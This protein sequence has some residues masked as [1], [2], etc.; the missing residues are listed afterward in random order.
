MVEDG[1]SRLRAALVAWLH[2]HP[3]GALAVA[4]SGG[5]DS[6]ALLA[7]LASL[8]SARQRGL[9]ALHVDHGLVAESRD[10]AAHAEAVARRL[11]VELRILRAEV[12]AGER[13]IEAAAREARYRLFREVLAPGEWLLLAHHAEDQAE[14][15]L[16]R[17][18]RG[19]SPRLLAGM[20]AAR[21][22]GRGYLARPLLDLSRSLL[23]EAVACSGLPW[24]EDP[25]NRD[26]RFD[27]AYL[28]QNVLPALT[29]RFPHAV[30]RIAASGRMI[31]AA[32][33]AL[34]ASPLCGG[35]DDES[36]AVPPLLGK[37]RDE[38]LLALELWLERRGLQPPPAAR[39]A[40]FLRQ[41]ATAAAD[42]A[43]VL[44]GPG[45]RLQ[46][47]RQRLH[48]LCWPLATLPSDLDLPWDGTRPLTLPDGSL[49]SIDGALP[50]SVHLALRV[51]A[52]RGGERI[53]LAPG[54]ARR[55][56][57]ELMRASAVPPWDRQRLP[58]LWQGDRLM[59]VGEH[60][61]DA[62]FAAL[63]QA[64]GLRLSHRRPL[65]GDIPVE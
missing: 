65:A 42:R 19:A 45:W 43:P 15:I 7:G 9:R 54:A 29:A 21:P 30:H 10:W 23:R 14:T 38:A 53:R 59:A 2:E 31:A 4:F 60:W 34:A 49:L 11:G 20:P 40:E 32:V 51:R 62:D 12:R 26:P 41:L 28:R 44:G 39:I 56:V 58:F 18:L 36:I 55:S 6:T 64:A 35:A 22:L 5:G 8:P 47:F 61:L 3:E 13:G 25:S 63:L 52:R 37:P 24:I 50:A 1:P 16:L 27:R 17:L 46:R 48:L 33:A 57:K